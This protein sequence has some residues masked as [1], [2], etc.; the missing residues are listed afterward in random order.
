[1]FVSGIKGN[2]SRWAL[3]MEV[4]TSPRIG[5]ASVCIFMIPLNKMTFVINMFGFGIYLITQN[6]YRNNLNTT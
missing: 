2:G 4:I 3:T 1:M 6:Q 5:S